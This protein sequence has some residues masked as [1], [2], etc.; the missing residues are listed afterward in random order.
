MK[1]YAAER[2][3]NVRGGR[4]PLPAQQPGYLNLVTGPEV[5]RLHA[6][7]VRGCLPV[8]LENKLAQLARGTL[9]EQF[10]EQNCRTM[11]SLIQAS[12]ARLFPEATTA[13]CERLLRVLAYVRKDDDAIPDYL[14]GGYVDDRQEVRAAV[15]ELGPVLQA[16]KAWRL[17]H[18]VP[19][20]WDSA[21]PGCRPELLA[22]GAGW[23]LGAETLARRC[24]SRGGAMPGRG[25][26][27]RPPS[28]GL[29]PDFQG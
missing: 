26:L 28:A 29:L 2:N 4:C 12:E 22:G 3:D 19:T 9:A 13:E 20:V 21:D 8:D 16:F 23:P 1:P 17:R 27:G 11:I 10:I 18:V 5:S 6:E 14:P 7:L 24:H 15:T 25:L